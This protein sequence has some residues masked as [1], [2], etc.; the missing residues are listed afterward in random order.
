MQNRNRGIIILNKKLILSFHEPSKFANV[1]QFSLPP[2]HFIGTQKHFVD[3][4]R[5]MRNGEGFGEVNFVEWK[6]S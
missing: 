3:S 2:N 6:Q 5:Y 1:L 4:K